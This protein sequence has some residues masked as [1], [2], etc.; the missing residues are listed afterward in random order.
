LK[1][2]RASASGVFS[3][4]CTPRVPPIQILRMPHISIKLQ[5]SFQSG[6]SRPVGTTCTAGP[7]SCGDLLL[8]RQAGFPST[9]PCDQRPR[10]TADGQFQASAGQRCPFFTGTQGRD[11]RANRHRPTWQ[12]LATVD[13][14]PWSGEVLHACCSAQLQDVADSAVTAREQTDPMLSDLHSWSLCSG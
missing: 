7:P 11:G 5:V 2:V 8:V 10:A 12:R 6:L 13:M 14:L 3:D 4:R 1:T 9:S